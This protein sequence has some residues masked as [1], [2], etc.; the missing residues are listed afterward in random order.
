MTSPVTVPDATNI[1]ASITRDGDEYVL[2]GRKWWTSGAASDRC[3][4]AIYMGISNP[5]NDTHARH[6]PRAARHTRA[7][8]SCAPCRCSDSIRATAAT[9]RSSST[10]CACPPRT[11]SGPRARLPDRQSSRPGGST[12]ACAIGMAERAFDLM[13]ARAARDVRQAAG[14]PG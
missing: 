8:R 6:D 2:N 9:A 12:T 10:T 1:E 4:I 7:W 3:K 11:C 5:D 13:C 14:A